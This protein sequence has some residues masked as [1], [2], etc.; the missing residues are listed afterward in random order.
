MSYDQTQRFLFEQADIRGEWV[1]LGG[2]FQQVLEAGE[3]S[4]PVSHLLGEFIAASVLLAGMLKFEGSLSLQMRGS[5]S[6]SLMMAECICEKDSTDVSPKIIRAL[7]ETQSPLL[8]VEFQEIFKGATLAITIEPRK[9]QRYQGVVPLQGKNL[10]SCLE[11]YFAQSEQLNTRIWL[12]VDQS[13]CAG[14]MLQELPRQ[15]VSDED[16][17]VEQW[18]HVLGLGATVRTQ[19][20]LELRANELLYRLFHQQPLRLFD[21]V[22]V[23]NRCTCT[24]ERTERALISIDR[25]EL[26]RMLL[27]DGEITLDC[28]FC[29]KRYHFSPAEIQ[30]L[31]AGAPGPRSH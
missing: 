14:L 5:G 23:C 21:P 22:P 1:R 29:R 15:L 2:S 26:E 12:A 4:P 19:E 17:R 7:A 9:G 3:Y 31:W 28:Q 25:E 18:E 8:Q 16:I 11:H 24:R 10:A 13:R 27:E 30:A 6:I 20:L